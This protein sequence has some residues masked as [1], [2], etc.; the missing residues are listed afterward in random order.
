MDGCY[1]KSFFCINIKMKGW[2]IPF[3]MANT[4][5]KKMS[6]VHNAA[7]MSRSMSQ[8]ATIWQMEPARTKKWNTLC[9]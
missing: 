9:M 3:K 2:P 1:P 8:T 6:M 4:M 7:P 5:K